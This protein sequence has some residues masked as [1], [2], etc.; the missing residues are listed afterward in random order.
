MAKLVGGGAMGIDMVPF[1]GACIMPASYNIG[2]VVNRGVGFGLETMPSRRVGMSR[3]L[4]AKST[5]ETFG[6]R[7][8][9]WIK[10][11]EVVI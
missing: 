6:L 1:M 7:C 8:R 11:P 9:F 5:Q 2:R 10:I 4:A 3:L